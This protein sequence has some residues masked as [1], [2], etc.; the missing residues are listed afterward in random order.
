MARRVNTLIEFCATCRILD[1]KIRPEG[2]WEAGKPC[3]V[4][5]ESDGRACMAALNCP[6]EPHFTNRAC[7]G[8]FFSPRKELQSRDKLDAVQALCEKAQSAAH[9]SSAARGR[10]G[11]FFFV[12]CRSCQATHGHFSC[13]SCRQ[14]K[15]PAPSSTRR[16][17]KA[18][19]PHERTRSSFCKV[20][21]RNEGID[22][23]KA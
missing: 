20:H 11:Q 3:Q 14:W 13:A 23:T 17:T 6:E 8:F 4:P 18:C 9:C 22:L 15:L 16:Q 12:G 10:A 7:A 5:G 19:D 2:M 21:L 1:P